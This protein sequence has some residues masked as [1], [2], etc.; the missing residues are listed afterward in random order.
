[1]GRLTIFLRI[2]AGGLVAAVWCATAR[3]QTMPGETRI[4]HPNGAAIVVRGVAARDDSISLTA[5]IANPGER[6]LRLDKSRSFVLEGAGH[7]MHYLNPPLG[8]PEL[9]I[10]PRSQLAAELVFIGPLVP[11]TRELQLSINQGIG[12]ADNPYD[13]APALRATLGVDAQDA[14]P[15]AGQANHPAGVTLRLRRLAAGGGSCVASVDA[16]NGNDRTIVLNHAGGMVLSDQRGKTSG[17]KPPAENRELVVPPSTR[18]E[19]ELVFDCRQLDTGG[20][21]TLHSNRGSAGTTDNPYDTLP[22]FALRATPDPAAEGAAMPAGSRASVAPIARSEL[23]PETREAAAPAPAPRPTKTPTAKSAGSPPAAAAEAAPPPPPPRAAVPHT[24]EELQAA[25]HAEKTD[26]GL[27]L[28][29]L[30]DTL[31]EPTGKTLRDGADQTLQK[32]AALIASE[33]AREVVVIAHTDGMGNDDDK[34]ALSEA[35]AQAVAG[36]LKA[37]A[38]KSPP[39]FVEKFYGRTRPVAPNKNAEGDD[40]PDG[41]AKNRRIEILI[42][43]R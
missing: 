6:E 9:S 39:R 36:W 28:V 8:N 32:L 17:L 34:L 13:D 15:V 18:L 19:A 33:Q 38:A 23:M 37:H 30:S 41:R 3:P 2:V 5:T 24:P 26:R 42:R 21:V 22:V 35:R 27:R 20:P 16:T 43:R 10:P 14:A 11:G 1:M 40:N 29:V 12:T 25:L 7:A 31:F 4:T